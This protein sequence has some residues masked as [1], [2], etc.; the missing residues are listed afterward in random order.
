[1]HLAFFFMLQSECIRS[2]PR[3]EF[4][5]KRMQDVQIVDRLILF[6]IIWK[7]K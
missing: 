6:I 2:F 5:F 3:K 7:V 1:M 4:V